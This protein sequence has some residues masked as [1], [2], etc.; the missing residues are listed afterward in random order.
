MFTIFEEEKIIS[1]LM[2]LFLVLSILTRLILGFLYQKM[3]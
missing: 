1:A 3:I 2:G